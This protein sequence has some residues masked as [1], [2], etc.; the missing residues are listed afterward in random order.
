MNQ[1]QRQT[2]DKSRLNIAKSYLLK[3]LSVNDMQN[4]KNIG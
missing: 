1:N 4:E 3:N 2:L